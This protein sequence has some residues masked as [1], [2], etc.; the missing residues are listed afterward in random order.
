MTIPNI[1]AIYPI[2]GKIFEPGLKRLTT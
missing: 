2:V 1:I